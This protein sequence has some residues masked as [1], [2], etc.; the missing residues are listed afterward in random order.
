MVVKFNLD[1]INIINVFSRITKSNVK[2]CIVQDEL[3]IFIVDEGQG[4]KAVGKQGINVKK[5][6]NLLRKRI[7][8]IE[9]NQDASKFIANLI[10]P[11]K[12]R[13]IL[14]QDD[15]III[16]AANMREKG[17]IF[18]R[19]RTNLKLIQEILSK[20]FPSLEIKLE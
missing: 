5:L 19:E 20:F 16:K 1:T 6:N 17:Q 9:Y 11:I 12:A 18:G 10:Y 8:I 15:K 13:E 7:K 4:G 2:D 3:I 14:I